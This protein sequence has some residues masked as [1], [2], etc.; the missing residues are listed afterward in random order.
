VNAEAISET[1][2]MEKIEAAARRYS[3]VAS[4]LLALGLVLFVGSIFY[5]SAQLENISQQRAEVEELKATLEASVKKLKER[6]AEEPPKPEE[7]QA[8]QEPATTPEQDQIDQLVKK[9]FSKEKGGDRIAAYDALTKSLRTKDYAVKKILEQGE[10]ELRKQPTER[11]FVGIYN[12][13]VT[14]TDMSRAVTQKPEFKERI[15]RFGDQAVEAF[16]RL[17]NRVAL[18]KK[19]LNSK[20]K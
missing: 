2:G 15:T 11:D 17:E 16:P 12:A 3:R 8:A 4:I 6:A 18:L 1:A 9:L 10:D 13:V 20:S 5:S 19:W 7:I 14:L